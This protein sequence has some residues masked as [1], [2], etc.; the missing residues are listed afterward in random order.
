MQSPCNTHGYLSKSLSVP[1]AL[2]PQTKPNEPHN[3]E[4]SNATRNSPINP[5]QKEDT[6]SSNEIE[7]SLECFH[8]PTALLLANAGNQD[9]TRPIDYQGIIFWIQSTAQ[10][11][12]R[13]AWEGPRHWAGSRVVMLKGSVYRIYWKERPCGDNAFWEMFQL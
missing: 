4:G 5:C 10:T 7:L 6:S 11:A 13:N 1:F 8:N 9:I 12:W 3:R 2:L